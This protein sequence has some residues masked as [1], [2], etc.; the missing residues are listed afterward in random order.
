[1]K[2]IAKRLFATVLA[3]ALVCTMVTG[4]AAN[5]A[6][7]IKVEVWDSADDAEP[8]IYDTFEDI[9]VVEGQIIKV[10][11]SLKPT[12]VT[13][14]GEEAGEETVAAAGD[15]TFLSA[16]FAKALS[17]NSI[18][19]VAQQT[20]VDGA[21]VFTFRPRATLG[22]GEFGAKV[23]GTDVAEAATFDY[24]VVKAAAQLSLSDAKPGSVEI[25]DGKDVAFDV[26]GYSE[27]ALVVT[28]DGAAL[29]AE[30]YT[31]VGNV[32]TIKNAAIPQVAKTYTVAISGEG[33]LSAESTFVV[34]EKPDVQLTLEAIRG[35]VQEN[36]TDNIEFAI[37]G[38][39]AGTALTVKINGEVAADEAYDIAGTN[40]VIYTHVVG[41]YTVAVDGEGYIA[42]EATFTITAKP[43]DELT[44]SAASPVSIEV[45]DTT[46]DIVFTVGGIVDGQ[47]IIVALD[48]TTLEAGTHYRLE[49]A[50]LT[51]LNAVIPKAIATYTVTVDGEGY[52]AAS[53]R[54]DVVADS[55]V[56]LALTGE[57]TTLQEDDVE[58]NVVY[59]LV[60]YTGGDLTVEI[61][62]NVVEA[63]VDGSTLTI[64][65]AALVKTLGT[66]NV[67]VSGEGYYAATATYA[68]TKKPATPDDPI[69]DEEKADNAQDVVNGLDFEIK[70]NKVV[71][72]SEINIAPEGEEEFVVQL[73][74]NVD[75][76]G[77]PALTYVEATGEIIYNPEAEG[78]P[79]VSKATVTVS[80]TSTPDIAKTET[81]Y[82]IPA[83][84][85]IAFGNVTAIATANGEDA[86]TEANFANLDKNAGDVLA[87][88]AEALNVVLGRKDKSKIAQQE[89][90]LD[91]DQNTVITLSE[92]KI[93]RYMMLGKDGYS[94]QDVQGARDNWIEINGVK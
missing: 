52:K 26:T 25:G 70:G 54:F 33:Y 93:F 66:H 68:V 59:T 36:V 87:A 76:K 24:D 81:I 12:T 63:T 27:G 80:V 19:Y 18:Q 1:M 69:E 90:T 43:D 8:T 83:G 32:L 49:G 23:G 61:D 6:S 20:V 21:T 74:H 35:T 79:F 88:Q 62:G 82:F 29:T 50:T 42:D 9:D 13:D 72:D 47:A 10:Y 39:V 94:W 84:T 56:Q 55:S 4:F 41:E 46:T 31:L 77:D 53:A 44:L 5:T 65:N 75:T 85:K 7:V 71:L 92:Y 67:R 45:D 51:I 11:T 58:T 3:L 17:N 89:E 91:Y 38:Y 30:Q 64:K 14:E 57:T 16:D 37:V 60:G 28:L 22:T 78:K 2:T 34:N 40:L 15:M 48:G 73:T 86:F